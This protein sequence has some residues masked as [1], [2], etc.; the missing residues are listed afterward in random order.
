MPAKL[1]SS[2][3]IFTETSRLVPLQNDIASFFK[4][5]TVKV[6]LWQSAEMRYV[7]CLRQTSDL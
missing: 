7:Q 1:P 4:G 6:A 2:E 5:I 3:Q